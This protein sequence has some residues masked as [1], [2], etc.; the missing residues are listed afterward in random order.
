MSKRAIGWFCCLMGIAGAA[1]AVPEK[2]GVPEKIGRSGEFLP[3][4]PSTRPRPLTIERSPP[5]GGG[6]LAGGGAGVQGKSEKPTESG[7]GEAGFGG[8]GV[9][10]EPERAGC[11]IDP[12]GRRGGAGQRPCAS[13]AWPPAGSAKEVS[14]SR[15]RV[16]ESCGPRPEDDPAAHGP[17]GSLR[18]GAAPAPRRPDSVPGR[19]GHRSRSC[20]R[21]LRLW[22][23]RDAPRSAGQGAQAAGDT[24]GACNRA[25]RCRCWHSPV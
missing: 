23:D 11:K 18:D 5:P 17:G 9:Q 25:T 19:G 8:S 10:E 24:R 12:R 16:E 6:R 15:G 1:P 21:A 3:S 4:R 22:D 13:V 20:R 7:Q 2:L 14:G